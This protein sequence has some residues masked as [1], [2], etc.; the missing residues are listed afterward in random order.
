MVE[1]L[2]AFRIANDEKGAAEFGRK[3][4]LLLIT[5]DLSPLYPRLLAPN[6]LPSLVICYAWKG[7]LHPFKVL[8]PPSEQLKFWPAGFHKPPQRVA[9]QLLL[10]THN[11]LQVTP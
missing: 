8:H 7:R 4:F 10:E 3:D 2:C 9:Q 5:K 6:H 1:R 11:S